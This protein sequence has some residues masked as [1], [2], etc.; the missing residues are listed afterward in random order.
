MT[1]TYQYKPFGVC[2]N[3]IQLSITDGVIDSISVS[4][5]CSGNGQ[6]VAAL[7]KGMSPEEAIRRMRGI[8]CKGKGTSCP[9]QI[10]RLLEK[11]AEREKIEK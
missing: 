2:P 10:A 8:E 7:L 6:G 3:E 1:K 9:D 5:G 11:I 4:G